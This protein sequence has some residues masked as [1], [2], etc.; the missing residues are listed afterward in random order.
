MMGSWRADTTRKYT[1]VHVFLEFLKGE[2]RYKRMQKGRVIKEQ[3]GEG[4]LNWEPFIVE[5]E[6]DYKN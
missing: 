5:F 6:M 3:E 1:Y 4:S 2:I